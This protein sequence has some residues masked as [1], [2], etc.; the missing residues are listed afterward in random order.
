MQIYKNGVY[1]SCTPTLY[2]SKYKS[3]GYIAVKMPEEVS[4][5]PVAEE[6]EP[7]E[8]NP[9]LEETHPVPRPKARPRKGRK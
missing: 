3:L 7:D 9:I 4:A 5:F 2:D 8:T 6:T 1:K